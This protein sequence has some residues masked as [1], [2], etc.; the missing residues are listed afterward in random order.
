MVAPQ[1][2]PPRRTLPVKP[3]CWSLPKRQDL[4]RGKVTPTGAIM[5]ILPSRLSEPTGRLVRRWA[6]AV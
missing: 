3:S 1:Q 5:R 4:R 6:A 2:S